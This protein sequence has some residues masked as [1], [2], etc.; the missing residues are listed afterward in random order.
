MV[1][2]TKYTGTN[3]H[4]LT[5]TRTPSPKKKRRCMD[6]VEIRTQIVVFGD[7]RV[8]FTALDTHWR[9]LILVVLGEGVASAILQ[10]GIVL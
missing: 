5:P 4:Q 2:L 3:S 6:N 8:V 1:S 10:Q 7:D 9:Q